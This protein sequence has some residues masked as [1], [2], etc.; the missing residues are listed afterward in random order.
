MA[1]AH[2]DLSMSWNCRRFD[3]L[4]WYL[5]PDRRSVVA[6]TS[7]ADPL[8]FEL[9]HRTTGQVMGIIFQ[10]SLIMQWRMGR[11]RKIGG[12]SGEERLEEVA[13]GCQSYELAGVLCFQC[14]YVCVCRCVYVGVGVGVGV[15]VVL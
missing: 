5:P 9:H 12:L 2:S 8:R 10:Q 4:E 3:L 6:R 7:K 13:V 14:V 15:G 1:P 11:Q